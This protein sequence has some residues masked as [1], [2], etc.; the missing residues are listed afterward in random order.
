MRGRFCSW[1]RTDQIHLYFAMA[2]L[3]TRLR[4]VDKNG[5]ATGFYDVVW[6]SLL[7]NKFQDGITVLDVMS[8][9]I[10]H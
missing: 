7:F 4:R 2:A 10:A 1:G 6:G 8:D 5:S 9:G 3:F